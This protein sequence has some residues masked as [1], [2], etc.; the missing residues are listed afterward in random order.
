MTRQSTRIAFLQALTLLI[1]A[2]PF[3]AAGTY[4]WQKHTWAKARIL[5]LEPRH[6][7]L[8]GMRTMLPEL[9]AATQQ[10]HTTITN[11]AYPA[12]QDSTNAGN[13]AQQRIRALFET[14][15]LTIGS[16]QV[17]EAKDNDR[18][19][20]ISIV[21]QVEGTLP[22]L[23]E[24]ILKLNDQTPAILVDSMNLQSIGSVRPASAQRIS[25]NFNFSV[26]RVRS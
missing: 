2:L 26:L 5:E 15:Q 22:S 8:Q 1:L 3:V 10:A 4:V 6:A 18:F 9:K 16:L 13:D 11:Q 23:H 7:R 21:L 12:S 24:A 17:L 14:N 19:Q 25:V 20:R